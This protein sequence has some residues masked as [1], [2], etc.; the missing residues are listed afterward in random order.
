LPELNFTN[1]DVIVAGGGHAGIEASLAA[2]RMDCRV[3]L[4]TMEKVAIGR[5]SCNPAIGGTAKGHLVREIDALGGE[6]A[7]IADATGI[8]F[9]MLN[10][11]KG[12]AV[13]SP[14]S[15]NDRVLY[16]QEAQR[17]IEKQSNIQIYEGTIRDINVGKRNAQSG[18]VINGSCTERWNNSQL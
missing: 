16:A 8:H 18:S 5:M 17:H 15:Q 10:L 12:P 2:A 1:Y 11:S 13:W 4:V 3:L 14:R 9:R 7:K 6:M